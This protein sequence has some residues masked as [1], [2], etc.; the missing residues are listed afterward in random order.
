MQKY[1]TSLDIAKQRNRHDVL[2]YLVERGRTR[3][4]LHQ[5]E[6]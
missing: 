6:H 5:T 4:V 3:H 1:C 2:E